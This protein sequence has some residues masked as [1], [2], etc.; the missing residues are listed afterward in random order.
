MLRSDGFNVDVIS[1]ENTPYL[2][3]K[4]L[5][6]PS[7]TISS[8][9]KS[10]VSTLRKRYDI[11]HG[12]NI[13]SLPA[14]ILS[15]CKA[16]IITLHGVY[17]SQIKMLHGKLLG[18]ISEV[19]ERK[20]IN[21][22]DAVTCV[23]RQCLEHYKRFF[24]GIIEYIPNAIDLR[25]MP[26]KPIR[27]FNKQVI[28]AGRLSYEKGVDVLIKAWR[29]VKGEAHLIILGDG[30]LRDMVIKAEKELNNL[31][32]LGCR[33]RKECLRYILGSDVLVLPSREEG[34]PTVLLEAMAL[35]TLVVASNIPGIREVLD[36]STGI[37]I[38][39]L[40]PE[41][42]AEAIINSVQSENEEILNAAYSRVVKFFS[43]DVVYRRYLNLYNSILYFI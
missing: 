24:K 18:R 41:L 28:Y 42:L 31:H 39:N 2:K 36:R 38:N 3:V 33:P 30:P 35:K 26:N 20:L 13:P 10:L 7:F 14:V 8:S 11:V 22:V 15:R 40:S 9:I 34:L 16:K 5:M 12:H 43:W 6:N 19:V 27:L 1:T 4:G 17:S 37:L 25:D 21:K 23:S 32:Y 29:L